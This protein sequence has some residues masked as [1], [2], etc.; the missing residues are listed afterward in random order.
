MKKLAILAALLAAVPLTAVTA[1][2]W[3]G[4]T[5][6]TS[7]GHRLGNPQAKTELIEFVSYTCPHCGKFFKEADGAIKLALVQPGKAS[8][9]IRHF[10]RDPID[11][12]AV[13]L[14]NC[15]DR[16]KFFGNHEMFFSR[17]E[18]WLSK[19][20]GAA[21][22]QQQRWTSGTVPER[23][24]AIS[25]D[26]GFYEMMERRGYTRAQVDRCLSDQKEIDALVEQAQADRA[27][28][29]VSGTPSFVVNGKLLDGVHQWSDLQKAL[30]SADK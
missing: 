24:R 14:A 28:Y 22:S 17:Q 16:A 20:Q 8:V 12:T 29:K 13:V 10:I 27:Q 23:L 6:A 11:L 21:R 9:E 2:N 1:Q 4:T 7:G 5:A 26:L 3:L 15:G 30:A 18:Q 19:A 25:S